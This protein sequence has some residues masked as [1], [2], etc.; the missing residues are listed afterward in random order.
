VGATELLRADIRVISATHRSL[1]NMVESGLFRA[2]LFYRLNVFPIRVPALRERI[3][4]LPL[5]VSALL[6][7]IAP[8]RKLS[9][10]DELL[11]FLGQLSFKGNIRELR[12][13]LERASLMCDGAQIEVKHL[14]AFD[15]EPSVSNAAAFEKVHD[16]LD[17]SN[18]TRLVK[19]HQGS[20]ADLAAQLGV[21]ERTLYRWIKKLDD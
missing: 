20:R 11:A 1:Q 15:L 4:D 2:D 21:S 3:S 9:I 17:L 5:L 7:R 10:S 12:N 13:I 14:Q 8:E 19:N 16:Q 18:L 6:V